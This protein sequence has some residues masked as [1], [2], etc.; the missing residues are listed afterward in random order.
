MTARPNAKNQKLWIISASAENALP[1]HTM[2]APAEKPK[3]LPITRKSMAAG[4]A[5]NAT[6]TLK[7]VIGKANMDAALTITL[8]ITCTCFIGI[9]LINVMTK[10]AGVIDYYWGPGFAVIAAVHFYIH[11]SGSIFEWIL[12]SAVVLWAIRLA[13]YLI[14]RH[15]NSTA[16]DGRYLEMRQTGGKHFWWT[17]LFKV[18]LL[19]AVLLWMI[20][21]PLH[22]AFGSLTTINIG[23]FIVGITVFLVGFVFEW[24]ADH[25]LEQGKRAANHK[26]NGTSLFTSG[27]WKQSRHPNYLG[28][29]DDLVGP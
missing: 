25:Q 23:L 21:S 4:S 12:F 11:G 2:S 16:E 15:H 20:A 9:W 26:E 18:F 5:P 19:Q 17:S 27:L 24:V 29:I 14:K 8:V 10:D 13:T 22:V 28:E 3:R 6:P 1:K 7:A